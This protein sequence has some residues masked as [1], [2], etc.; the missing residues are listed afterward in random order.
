MNGNFVGRLLT[1]IVIIAIGVMFL[2]RQMGHV[3][4]DVGEVFSTYWPL[5]LIFF[6]IQGLISN[7][8]HQ[9]S[10][11][12]NGIV[13]IIGFVFLGRNLDWFDW[14]IGDIIPYIW[15]II[16]IVVGFKMLWRP[17]RNY[18]PPSDDWEQYR[19]FSNDED[20]PPAPPLHPD[21][22]KGPNLKKEDKPETMQHDDDQ[23]SWTSGS[24]GADYGEEAPPFKKPYKD[25]KQEHKRAY[26]EW[27]KDM[28]HG[29]R[30]EH[31]EWWNHSD[32]GVQSRS[33]FIG[34]IHI[35][36]DYWELKP[37]NVSHF[38]GDT[39]L[40]LTKAQ[41][42][43]GETR[44]TISSFIGDVKVYV[45]N[46]Y[47][48]G[49]QVITSSFMGD[50]KILDQKEGGMFKNMSIQSPSYTE[51]DKKIKLIVSTFIGDVRVTK[52]G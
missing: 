36:Q 47:E 19:P 25:W 14:S 45:P 24:T 13:L 37:L 3:S 20:V 9:G 16:I 44:V 42:A 34:D 27:K 11:W 38:I 5:I 28:K 2:L 30:K 29:H 4:F 7:A 51:S 6:G 33:G 43:N 12:W 15:P 41:V 46:D 48:I 52:V 31:V 49:V 8:R 23:V 32:K 22:T 18:T 17:K 10:G 21:P 26:K 40:D 35:G 39:I 50:V 1:G